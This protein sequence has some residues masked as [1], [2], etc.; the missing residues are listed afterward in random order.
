MK[1]E[2]EEVPFKGIYR[3]A[4]KNLFSINPLTSVVL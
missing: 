2:M 4:S 3:A 1:D